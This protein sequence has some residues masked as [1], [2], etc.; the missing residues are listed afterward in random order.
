ME[1]KDITVSVAHLDDVRGG[2]DIDVRSVGL[3]VGANRAYSSASS[4]GLGNVTSSSVN[5]IAPQTFSQST[6]IHAVEVDSY[7]TTIANSLVG[8]PFLA[9]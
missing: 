4:L 6:A 9:M 3:Q 7:E 2:Q 5:Q 8:F 1:I